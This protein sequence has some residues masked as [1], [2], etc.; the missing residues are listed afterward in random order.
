MKKI[1]LI[2]AIMMAN[3]FLFAAKRTV[4]NVLT[5]PAQ[6]SNLQA[7]IDASA[8]GDT[9]YIHPSTI[10]YGSI[11]INKKLTLLG[12]GYD[13]RS[14]QR[15]EVAKIGSVS[16]S[17]N[18]IISSSSYSSFI[19]LYIT[20]SINPTYDSC[21]HITLARNVLA[22]NVS[23]GTGNSFSTSWSIFNNIINGSIYIY[24]KVG[25]LMSNNHFTSGGNCISSNGAN[26][27]PNGVYNN[28]F[29]SIFQ[30][31]GTGILQTSNVQ[32]YNNIFNNL[33]TAGQN[34]DILI[35]SPTYVNNTFTKNLT[36]YISNNLPPLF[37]NNNNGSGNI[38]NQNPL[39][40]NAPTFGMT[41]NSDSIVSY[42]FRLLPAS[43]G[44]NMGT[45][46]TDIGVYGGGYPFK[47]DQGITALPQVTQLI[48]LNPAVPLNNSLNVNSKGKKRD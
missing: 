34:V 40:T 26:P 21:H 12:P 13:G 37:N 31:A 25:N 45:D 1:T 30:L 35:N 36:Y 24:D 32:Y 20:S 3:T 42:N 11:V 5:N 44:K 41:F 4:S 23:L 9:L 46:A 10:N 43:P 47:N 18:G 27:G 29:S 8:Y 28:N 22:S 19:G 38:N 7:A 15:N 14:Y 2:L 17:Y 48:I 39:F 16:L 6:Y 33:N